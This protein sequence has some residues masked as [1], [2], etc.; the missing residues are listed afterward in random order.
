MK[1]VFVFIKTMLLFNFNLVTLLSTNDMFVILLTMLYCN[2]HDHRSYVCLEND[3]FQIDKNVNQND[4]LNASIGFKSSG[5]LVLSHRL[6]A[7]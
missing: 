4:F 7:T 3:F 5:I 6:K 1:H 2:I